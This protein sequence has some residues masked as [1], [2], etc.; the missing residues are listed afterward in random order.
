[1]KRIKNIV[2]DLGSM[3]VLMDDIDQPCALVVPCNPE[4]LLRE[5]PSHEN[6]TPTLG[7][8]LEGVSFEV[9]MLGPRQ[10]P[11]EDVIFV[12]SIH[13]RQG[14]P[15]VQPIIVFDTPINMPFAGTDGMVDFGFE[16]V[17]AM[18]INKLIHQVRSWLSGGFE[19]RPECQPW[20]E[21]VH[22][23]PS[24]TGFPAKW[25]PSNYLRCP[26]SVQQRARFVAWLG[27]VFASRYDA[28]SAELLQVWVQVVMP[29]VM[30]NIMFCVGGQ[31]EVDHLTVDAAIARASKYEKNWI[32][33]AKCTGAM[34]QP[35]S[36]THPGPYRP[37][38]Y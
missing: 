31:V 25:T 28:D 35:A 32:S 4:D 1:M 13:L 34:P 12:L 16:N 17:S 36:L 20:L 30:K 11:Y 5:D 29:E 14:W 8:P 24:A 10:T 37:R 19:R 9:H 7:M 22:G 6:W 15:F 27:R 21:E 33:A 3:P 23:A 26:E 38:G 18:C 2:G